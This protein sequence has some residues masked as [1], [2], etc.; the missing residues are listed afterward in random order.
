MW[1]KKLLQNQKAITYIQVNSTQYNKCSYSSK[2]YNL[3]WLKLIT[4][5]WLSYL[6]MEPPIIRAAITHCNYS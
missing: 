4:T 3:R 5:N 6:L 1:K 2:Y